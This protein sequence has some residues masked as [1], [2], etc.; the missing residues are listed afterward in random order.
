MSF[1]LN[2]DVE[3]CIVLYWMSY[4]W[5][6][7]LSYFLLSFIGW[8][9]GIKEQWALTKKKVTNFVSIFFCSE[10]YFIVV[11]SF[12]LIMCLVNFKKFEK[13]VTLKKWDLVSFWGVKTHF[14]KIHL[15]WCLF[16]HENWKKLETNENCV[17]Y[18]SFW[19]N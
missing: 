8:K 3:F 10:N 18:C 16:M 7:C 17:L 1:K 11:P 2:S 5:G 6:W 12:Y 13:I 14:G 19:S 15:K 9:I 4:L